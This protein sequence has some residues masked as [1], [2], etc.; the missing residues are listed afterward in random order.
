MTSAIL[1]DRRGKEPQLTRIL[2]VDQCN[3]EVV[4]FTLPVLS[5]IILLGVLITA[6]LTHAFSAEEL[7]EM[8]ICL[9]NT[10]INS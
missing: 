6:A 4:M 5:G 9:E 8:G 2:C 10:H 3:T 1:P 7:T